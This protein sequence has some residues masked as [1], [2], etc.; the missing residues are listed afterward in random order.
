MPY[1]NINDYADGISGD[2]NKDEAYQK[3]VNGLWQR[4]LKVRSSKYLVSISGQ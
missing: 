3:H 1:D 4:P 2:L